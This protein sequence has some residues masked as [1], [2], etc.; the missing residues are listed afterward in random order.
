MKLK[1]PLLVLAVVLLAMTG[2]GSVAAATQA[3]CDE[4]VI[5]SYGSGNVIGTP[6]RAQVTFSVQ[7][8]NID[9]KS[10]T[11]G[12]CGSDDKSD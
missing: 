9:V 6:D 2:I 4:N 1:I 8:E 10:C 3:T 11:N 5:H 7:T 12:K